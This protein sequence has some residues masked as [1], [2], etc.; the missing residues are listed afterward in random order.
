MLPRLRPGGTCI[1]DPLFRSLHV[2]S[3]RGLSFLDSVGRDGLYDRPMLLEGSTRI[4]LLIDTAVHPDPE[5][6]AHALQER[7]EGRVLSA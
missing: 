2:Q 6:G 1:K 3:H 7:P 4:G 5:Q